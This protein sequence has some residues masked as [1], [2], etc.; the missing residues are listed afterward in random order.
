MGKKFFH[1]RKNPDEA[2]N[3][4]IKL[5]KYLEKLK[6]NLHKQLDHSQSGQ[7]NIEKYYNSP[8]N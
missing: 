1:Y 7:F 2:Y 8:Q 4:I 3:E 5:P 6:E